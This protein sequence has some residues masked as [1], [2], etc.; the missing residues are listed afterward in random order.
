VVGLDVELDQL[1]LEVGADPPHDPLHA[2]EAPV[3]E[4]VVPVLH[5]KNQVHVCEGGAVSTGT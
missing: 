4:H 2:L 3:A 5:D 1:A